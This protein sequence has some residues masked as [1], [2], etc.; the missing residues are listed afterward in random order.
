MGPSLDRLGFDADLRTAFDE[1]R[2]DALYPARI[3]SIHKGGFEVASPR[4]HEKA[5]LFGTLK[6]AFRESPHARPAVGDW[7][8]VRAQGIAVPGICNVL[9]RKSAFVRQAAGRRTEPQIIVANI[10]TVFIVIGLDGDFNERRLERYVATVCE[11]GAQPVILLNK[12]DLCDDPGHYIKTIAQTAPNVPV[13]LTRAKA[14]RD[15]SLSPGEAGLEAIRAFLAPGRTIALVGSSG[16]GKSTLANALIGH[17]RQATNEVRKDRKGQH[18]TTHRAL[19][20]IPDEAGED[21][22]NG[23]LIDTPGIRELNLWDAQDGLEELFSDVERLAETCR[24][25]DCGHTKEPGCAVQAAIVEGTLNPARVASY[26]KLLQE[27][28][29]QNDRVQ[30]WSQRGGGRPV[31]PPI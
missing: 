22:G 26:E 11:T 13:C 9:P 5:R 3:T 8:A 7:V 23:M 15:K 21:Y 4:G 27:Q 31:K 24:F 6:R 19:I 1:L 20:P 29:A 16:V 18:T 14:V 12:A 28:Q 25:R 30:A 10:D 2:D 17:D